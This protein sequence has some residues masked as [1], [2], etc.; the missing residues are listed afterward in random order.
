MADKQGT[1][2]K[3]T[4]EQV[5]SL[6]AEEP[7]K[8]K[9]SRNM[10]ML[11]DSGS[12]EYGY[13]F[14][15]SAS[16][17]VKGSGGGGKR[18]L[19]WAVVVIFL[20]GQGGLAFYVVKKRKAQRVADA[21]KQA[22]PGS[23]SDLYAKA[24]ELAGKGKHLEA[25]EALSRMQLI[26]KDEDMLGLASKLERK[27][28]AEPQLE[29]ARRMVKS[30]NWRGASYHLD[31]V[32]VLV[33]KHTEASKMLAAVKRHL[34]AAP[35]ATTPP[36]T[37][38]PATTPPATTPPRVTPPKVAIRT[39]GGRRSYR[40]RLPR[41]TP[42]KAPAAA[43]KLASLSITCAPPAR[44]HVDGQL[45]GYTP[46]EG[47]RV[48]AGAHAVTLSA[49]GYRTHTERVTLASGQAQSIRRVLEKIP[50]AEP[51]VAVAPRPKPVVKPAVTPTPRPAPARKPI[52]RLGL[53][54]KVVV[55]AFKGDGSRSKLLRV[56]CIAVEKIVAKEVG[57]SASG[58]TGALQKHLYSK[59]KSSPDNKVTLYP[60]TMGYLIAQSLVRNKPGIRS[61]LVQYHKSGKLASLSRSNWRP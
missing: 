29:Q 37:T 33:P 56:V 55:K 34:G 13:S 3:D 49:D 43:P 42:K 9:V 24:K 45:Q 1:G 26:T 48:E 22:G 50:A 52:P 8:A 32:L 40:H 58:A 6:E 23:G 53:P 54:K 61:K 39:K 2:N 38:P 31:Q 7:R 17:S 30:G 12:G 46:R 60:R 44:I 57:E 28:R 19:L 35:P 51:A 5:I 20:V 59:A 36:A 10:P 4:G 15:K 47:L 16:S 21:A 11:S 41:V 18:P 14:A 27:I 25:L